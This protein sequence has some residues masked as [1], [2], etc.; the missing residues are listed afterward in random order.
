MAKRLPEYSLYKRELTI[1]RRKMDELKKQLRQFENSVDEFAKASE[2]K[3]Y[4]L[5][6]PL[7]KKYR[8]MDAKSRA[9]VLSDMKWVLEVELDML[10]ERGEDTREIDEVMHWLFIRSMQYDPD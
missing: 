10:K 3:A 9:A 2:P 6:F 7:P 1:I 4:M 5:D 8:E